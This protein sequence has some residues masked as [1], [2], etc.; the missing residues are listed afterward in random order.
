[1]TELTL[2]YIEAVIAWS[3]EI[4]GVPSNMNAVATQV[5]SCLTLGCQTSQLATLQGGGTFPS[6][7][8]FGRAFGPDH[9]P[10]RARVVC[11]FVL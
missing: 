7:D 11:V 8:P 10:R 3:F 1:M 9:H 6:H 5:E 4:M 2:H